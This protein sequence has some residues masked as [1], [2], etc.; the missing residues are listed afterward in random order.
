MKILIDPDLLT[1]NVTAYTASSSDASY[2]AANMRDNYP[3]NVWKAASGTVATIRLVVSKGSAVA[4]FNT[5]AT[6]VTISYGAGE[7]Y[8]NES[9]YANES[10]YV[11]STSDPA[12]TVD[13]S[14]LSGANGKLWAEYTEQT[15]PHIVTI[16]LTAGAAPSIGVLRAG[17]V[18]EFENPGRDGMGEGS[19]DYSIEATMPNGANYFRKR[20]VVRT[21]SGLSMIETR[22]NAFVFKHDIFDAVGP[23]PLAIRLAA[24]SITD[25]ELIVFAKRTNPVTIEHITNTLTRINFELQ[26]VI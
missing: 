23:M 1:D 19:V 14:D 5:N 20:D 12:A 21:H 11:Y 8:V 7:G 2:P 26:E 3:G 18:E 15:V 4:M 16:V 9:G 25:D 6:A 10:G 24:D 17:N 22:A 13:A